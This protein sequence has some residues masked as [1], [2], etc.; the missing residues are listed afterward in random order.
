[1]PQAVR[2]SADLADAVVNVY[3]RLADWP[4]RVDVAL[5]HADVFAEVFRVH[6]RFP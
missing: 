1:M 4:R 3:A 5:K 6:W 2:V